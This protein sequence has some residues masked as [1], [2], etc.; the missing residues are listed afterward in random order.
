[1]A[2]P[3]AM[4]ACC[5]A[6]TGAARWTLQLIADRLVE[7]NVVDSICLER[8]RQALKQTNSTPGCTSAGALER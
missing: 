8:V 5:E 3:V 1:M 6:P 7:L 4:I 2:A